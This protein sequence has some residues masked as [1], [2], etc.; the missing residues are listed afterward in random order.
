MELVFLG[1]WKA[2]KRMVGLK[3]PRVSTGTAK[4]MQHGLIAGPTE[5]SD[6][7]QGAMRELML[8]MCLSIPCCKT[9][10]LQQCCGL[11]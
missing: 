4:S 5:T 9:G 10:V 11:S 1:A 8:L 7:P 2:R 6:A 3:E